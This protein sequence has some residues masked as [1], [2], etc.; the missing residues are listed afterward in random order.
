MAL[1]L[2]SP[3]AASDCSGNPTALGTSRTVVVDPTEHSRIGTM[4]Y[5]ETL[6]L[7]DK[8]V[9]LTFDDGPLP[10]FTGKIL[11]ILAAQ[12]VRATYFIVGQMARAYPE[13]VRRVHAEGHT[14]GTHSMHHPQ[15]FV[16]QPLHRAEDE[17]AHGIAATAAALRPAGGVAPFFRFPGLNRSAAVER[18]LG[19]RGL[20]AWSADIASD[21][22]RDIT[23]DEVVRRTLQRLEAKGKGIILLHDIQPRTVRALPTL[24][25]ELKT[26]GYRIVHVVPAS[27]D[28]PRTATAPE[29][30]RPHARVKPTHVADARTPGRARLDRV[31]HA[32]TQRGSVS[33]HVSWSLRL[34][35]LD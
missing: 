17:I 8:E 22:W 18:H 25:A 28:R 27:K 16:A 19:S 33:P 31:A 23:P 3:L 13:L 10:P 29:Q 26:R 1:P 24:L 9:V 11:D 34:R 2:T 35:L 7:L 32:P 15:P 14:V 5:P 4:D 12:C 30:W 20:M 21:D 6:P